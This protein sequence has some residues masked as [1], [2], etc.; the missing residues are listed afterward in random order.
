MEKIIS[1]SIV[2]HLDKYDLLANYQHG[3]RAGHSCETQLLATIED[4]SLRLDKRK[5][6]DLLIL[7][8]SKAFDT[9]NHKTICAITAF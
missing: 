9:I 7:D 8:F 4:L 1:S 2:K 6:T 3:F 5:H